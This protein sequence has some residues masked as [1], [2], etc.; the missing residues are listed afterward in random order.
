MF[1]SLPPHFPCD[2]PK[3]QQKRATRTAN[4]GPTFEAVEQGQ[5]VILVLAAFP[6]P[7]IPKRLGRPGKQVC[8]SLQ[9][10]GCREAEQEV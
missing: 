5:H 9:A 4:A 3:L 6:H 8:Q 2:T 1:G 10:C 7:G